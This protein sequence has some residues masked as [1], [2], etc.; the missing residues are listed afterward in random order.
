MERF[1]ML[2]FRLPKVQAQF[3][4][5][6]SDDEETAAATAA[7]EEPPTNDPAL[8]LA[9]IGAPVLLQLGC[10][11]LLAICYIVACRWRLSFGGCILDFTRCAGRLALTRLPR[12]QVP[13]FT[14]RNLIQPHKA[15]L[16]LHNKH[17]SLFSFFH[18]LLSIC[19]LWA[20]IRSL[21]ISSCVSC[22]W[23]WQR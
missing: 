19:A 1:V 18:F 8:S 3:E 12:L 10:V 7:A 6:E 2:R 22:Q 13:E 4:V 5:I 14:Y 9:Q 11:F 20:R 17:Q 16:L 23:P 21:A 15:S